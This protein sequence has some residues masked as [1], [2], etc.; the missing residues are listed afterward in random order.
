MPTKDFGICSKTPKPWIWYDLICPATQLR[1]WARSFLDEPD[2]SSRKGQ[3]PNN[4]PTKPSGRYQPLVA[5]G[6]TL[7]NIHNQWAGVKKYE[8]AALSLNHDNT[9]GQKLNTSYTE[10]TDAGSGKMALSCTEVDLMS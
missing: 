1:F 2:L 3:D 6:L 5:I 10:M 4:L 9:P 8:M 7:R